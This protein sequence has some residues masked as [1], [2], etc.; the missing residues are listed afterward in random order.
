MPNSEE[1]ELLSERERLHPH[2]TQKRLEREIER[3]K[4]MSP[5][6][7]EFFSDGEAKLEKLQKKLAA[8]KKVHTKKPTTAESTKLKDWFNVDRKERDSPKT[9]SGT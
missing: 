6:S 1:D 8:I 4:Q 2:S 9:E 3:I 5:K 7:K